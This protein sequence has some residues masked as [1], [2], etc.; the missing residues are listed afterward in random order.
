MNGP[1]AG[2]GC[3]RHRITTKTA[4]YRPSRHTHP[5][6]TLIR[7]IRPLSRSAVRPEGWGEGPGRSGATPNYRTTPRTSRQV[8]PEAVGEAP[9]VGVLRQPLPCNVGERRGRRPSP[10]PPGAKTPQY[11]PDQTVLQWSRSAGEGWGGARGGAGPRQTI[12]TPRT[13]RRPSP[14]RRGRS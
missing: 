11:V 4:S 2:W 8:P 9:R 12:T 14:S 1:G 5:S 10:A 7:C 3:P 13:S 6:T